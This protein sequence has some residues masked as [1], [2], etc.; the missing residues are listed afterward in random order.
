[1]LSRGDGGK[2]K[3]REA[4]GLEGSASHARGYGGEG[5]GG[6]ETPVMMA[7]MGD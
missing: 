5:E 6:E 2:R 4:R 1:M 3:G 7:V